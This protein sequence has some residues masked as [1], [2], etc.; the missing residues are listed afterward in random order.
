MD[1]ELHAKLGRLA[2]RHHVSLFMLLQ[3]AVA[4]LYTRL[5]AGTDI[6]LG[7][8]TAGRTDEALNDLIGFF[9]NTLVLRTDLSGNPTFTELLDRVRAANLDAYTHQDVPFER[10][11]EHLNPARVP[12]RHPLFQTVITFDN[13]TRAELDFAGLRGVM[14]AV[15][16]AHAQFDLNFTFTETA[17]GLT[18]AIEYA[19][20]LFDRGTATALAD[21]LIRVLRAVADDPERA[22][23]SIDVLSPQERELL[24]VTRNDTAADTDFSRCVHE[25]FEAEAAAHPDTVAVALGETRVTYAELNAR[26]NHIAHTLLER[27]LAAEEPVAVLMERSVELI[28]AVLAVAKAGGTYAPL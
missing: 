17:G 1:A 11:V 6:P 4:T 14:E 5:G 13:Q 3:A 16:E 23:G 20:D 18:G 2:A 21:R 26:A 10:L 15:G 8:P 7:T 22:I 9:V 19:C 25:L 28:A 24:L 12:A 27:G